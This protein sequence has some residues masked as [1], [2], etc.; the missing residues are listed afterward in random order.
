M[1]SA[2]TQNYY[3]AVFSTKNRANVITPELETRLHPF[4]G[5]I[6]REIGRAHV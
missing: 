5:G 4:I 1:P 3:H 2:Y 6:L